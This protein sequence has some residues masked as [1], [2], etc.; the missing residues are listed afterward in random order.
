MK[1]ACVE[2][3][4]RVFS[5]TYPLILNFLT[6]YINGCLWDIFSNF[7][8]NFVINNYVGE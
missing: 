7:S 8:I 6:L 1:F 3:A 5:H 4:V 2:R